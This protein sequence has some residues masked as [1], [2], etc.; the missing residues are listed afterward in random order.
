MTRSTTIET[1][2]GPFTV[3]THDGELLASG[4]TRDVAA[5]VALVH[6]RLRDPIVTPVE[7]TCSAVRFA[8]DAVVAYY[9]GELT[10]PDGV[11]VRQESGEFRRH[12][13]DVLRE[14]APGQCVTYRDL[15]TRAGRPT[16]VRAAAGACAANAAALFV[17]CHRVLRSDGG[18]GGFRYGALVKR[19]LLAREGA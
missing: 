5:L 13:W 17:P 4:W 7:P 18:L 10:A 16:A 15:A 11:S 9:D 3:V 14:V 12:T 1:P 2:D 8:V 6:R 19:S